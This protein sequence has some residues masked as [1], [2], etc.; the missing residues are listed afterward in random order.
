[1][2]LEE[3]WWYVPVRFNSQEPRTY[4]YYDTLTDIEDEIAAK[5]HLQVLFVPAG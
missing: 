3:G 4:E 5:E 2:H 1:M